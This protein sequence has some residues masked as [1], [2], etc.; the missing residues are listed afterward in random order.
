[1][2]NMWPEVVCPTHLQRLFIEQDEM[3]CPSG[4]RWSVK[5]NIARIVPSTHNYTDAFGLQWKKYRRTQLDSHTKT[6]L[7]LDRARRC[8]GESCWKRLHENRTT[9]VLEVGCGAGR[10]TEI[11]LATGAQI[12]SVDMSS[13]VEANQ[14]N[15]PQNAHHRILQADVR[16]L[17]FAPRQFDLVFCLGV[18]QHTPDSEQTIAKLY[19]QVK[20]G[21]C[22]VIDHYTYTLSEFSK[23]AP[24]FRA[25]LRRVAPERGLRWSQRLVD[26]FLPLHKAAR[27][28]WL[29]QALLSRVSP[30]LTYYHS[31]PL[32]DD[33]QRE[34][35]LL[36]THDSLTDRFK[37]F[38][39]KKQILTLLRG[40]GAEHIWCQRGGNGVEARCRRP[41]CLS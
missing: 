24:L 27:H 40:L 20:P 22:L 12:T 28:N 19:E 21:G 26:L 7:T 23:S 3:V 36:D 31:L 15:F 30:I 35:A 32:N 5:S 4:E 9:Q 34:W 41:P 18:V 14:E 13:A 37:R 33:L 2:E 11:L 1:M 8:L 6:T 17:P 16:H 29:A 25:I 39:T 38:R 10:F